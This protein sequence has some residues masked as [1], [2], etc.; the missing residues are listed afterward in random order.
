MQS[1]DATK[2]PVYKKR[3]GDRK[4]GRL[5]RSIEPMTIFA[6]YVMGTRNDANNYISDSVEL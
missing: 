5:I 3:R 4:D 6:L 2:M 1:D